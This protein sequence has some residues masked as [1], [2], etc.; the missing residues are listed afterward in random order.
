MLHILR[1]VSASSPPAPLPAPIWQ[2]Q[3][4]PSRRSR[5][6]T[7]QYANANITIARCRSRIT[8]KRRQPLDKWCPT[9]PRLPSCWARVHCS[10]GLLRNVNPAHP[11]S[12]HWIYSYGL[13]DDYWKETGV[14]NCS[15]PRSPRTVS[16]S[17]TLMPAATIDLCRVAGPA[18]R[19][20]AT[21][22]AGP[23]RPSRPLGSANRYGSAGQTCHRVRY[24]SKPGSSP[25]TSTGTMYRHWPPPTRAEGSSLAVRSVGQKW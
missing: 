22:F 24:G 5:S 9:L 25:A 14:V 8:E 13:E 16:G 11:C 1:M 17:A 12:I 2:L 4:C 10:G 18:L 20:T 6:A 7:D 23:V 19:T 15:G 21:R 3:P